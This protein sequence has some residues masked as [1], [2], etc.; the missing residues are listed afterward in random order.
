MAA[1]EPKRTVTVVRVLEYHGTEEWL[2][3]TFDGSR[4][5]MKGKFD[6]SGGKGDGSCYIRSGLV[7]W[8]WLDEA[9]NPV[10]EESPIAIPPGTTVQ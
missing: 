7:E 10:T 5:P 6:P 1:K 4:I 9:G 2:K 3:S 8:T